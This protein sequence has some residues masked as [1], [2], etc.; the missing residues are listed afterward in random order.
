[1]KTTLLAL[2]LTFAPLLP[3]LH[4]QQADDEAELAKKLSNP[5][6]NLISVPLQG[7]WDFH[8]GPN[9]ATR[10]TLN[11]QPVIPVSLSEDANLIIRTILPVIDAG[12]PAPGVPSA[13][14]LGDTTQSFFYSPK[15]PTEGGWIWGAGPVLLWPTATDSQLGSG[16]WGAGPTVVLLKQTNGWTFGLLANHIWSYAGSDSRPDVNSTFLQPF[17]SY[18]TKTHTSITLNTEST[19]DWED[20]QWTVPLNLMVGQVFKIGSQPM[21]F[22]VG[23]RYYAEKPEG[24]PT[25]GVRGV[26]TFL[27][28]K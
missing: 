21:Q 9:D 3:S 19:Y 5:V 28:P 15:Q 22:T 17:V 4:A 7:N 18:T 8:I 16:K 27:F 6:A 1:M 24:G 2:A 26:L 13:S 23:A 10:F 20:S 11:V 12:S 25:W 14:G